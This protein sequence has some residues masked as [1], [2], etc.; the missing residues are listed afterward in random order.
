[1]KIKDMYFL[2][3]QSFQSSGFKMAGAMDLPSPT[4]E[5]RDTDKR[6]FV[7]RSLSLEKIKV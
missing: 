1:M 3:F 4:V 2:Y 6:I 7:N 5:K